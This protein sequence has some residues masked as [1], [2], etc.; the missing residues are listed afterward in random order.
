MASEK[1]IAA[2]RA[3][4]KKSTGPRTGAGKQKS[5]RNA[6]RLRPTPTTDAFG[7]YWRFGHCG[8]PQ[9]GMRRNLDA[10]AFNTANSSF[11][12]LFLACRAPRVARTAEADAD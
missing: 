11:H 7:P 3:N 10:S 8:A 2:N 6:F 4:A 12:D 1:Q 9:F 5:S